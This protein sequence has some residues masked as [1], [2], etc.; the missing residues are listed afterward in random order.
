MNIPRRLIFSVVSIVLVVGLVLLVD[1][2]LAIRAERKTAQEVRSI[3]GL[4]TDPRVSIGGFPYLLSALTGEVSGISAVAFDVDVPEFGM[5]NAS[6]SYSTV[7]ITPSQLISGDFS[8]AVAELFSRTLSLDGVALGNQLN[9]TNLEIANPYDISP[10]GGVASEVQL[11]GTPVGFD[12][13]VTVVAALRLNG[14]WFHLIPRQVI[15]APE[16]REKDALAAFQWDL[17]TRRLPLAQQAEA[18]YVQGG[19]IYFETQ[20]RNVQVQV[21]DLSPIKKVNF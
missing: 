20:R 13:P 8:G 5:L 1:L 15:S 17:D 12:K 6:T 7:E 11:S 4:A 19:S 14:P 3:A 16:G 10:G 18:V 21:D 2:G 9:I